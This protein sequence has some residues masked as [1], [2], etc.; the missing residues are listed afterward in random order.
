MIMASDALLEKD[1][2]PSEETVRKCLSN[3][4][5]RCTGYE[6]QVKAVLKAAQCMR[7]GKNG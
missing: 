1:P 5:C 4:L 6:R 2:N 3:N 7:E